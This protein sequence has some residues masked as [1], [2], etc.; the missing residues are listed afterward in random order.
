[1][2]TCSWDSFAAGAPRK[3]LARMRSMISATLTAALLLERRKVTDGSLIAEV[4]YASARSAGGKLDYDLENRV[5]PHAPGNAGSRSC[6]TS[7][8][9]G[10]AW[11]RSSLCLIPGHSIRLPTWLPLRRGKFWKINSRF[12]GPL[13]IRMMTRGLSSAVPQIRPKTSGSLAWARH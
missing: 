13:T 4:C 11:L 10:P 8:F 6:P 1:M 9:S 12:S 2:R 5:D 7:V 3:S